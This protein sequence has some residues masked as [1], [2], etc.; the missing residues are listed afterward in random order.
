VCATV[1]QIFPRAAAKAL[2]FVS[3]SEEKHRRIETEAN[4]RCGLQGHTG[5]P[6]LTKNWLEPYPWASVLEYVRRLQNK[7]AAAMPGADDRASH[8]PACEQARAHWEKTRERRMPLLEALRAC[9]VC[10]GLKPFGESDCA[11]F[12]HIAKAIVKPLTSGFSPTLAAALGAVIEDFVNGASD[13]T[14]LLRMLEIVRSKLP[15][16]GDLAQGRS[17][18]D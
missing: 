18:L 2:G 12:A 9:R 10:H 14:E 17:L 3:Q 4:R 1:H 8:S 5:M 7:P 13:E 6:K 15:D 11:S 16:S